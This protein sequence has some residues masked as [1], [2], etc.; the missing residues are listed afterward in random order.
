MSGENNPFF[1]RSHSEDSKQKISTKKTGKS[2]NKGAYRSPENR[3]K[4]SASLT[5]RKNPA[6]A[7]K[8]RGRKLSEQHRLNT[9]NGRKGY[10]HSAATKEKLRQAAVAQWS[11]QKGIDIMEKTLCL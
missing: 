1:G 11:K 4:I 3:A 5:G 6:A 10:V 7:E 9:I 8:L 2:V